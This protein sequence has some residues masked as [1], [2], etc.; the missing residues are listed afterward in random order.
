MAYYQPD[1]VTQAALAKSRTGKK[2]TLAEQQLLTAHSNKMREDMDLTSA[3]NKSLEAANPYNYGGATPQVLLDAL[4][5]EQ[6]GEQTN[7]YEVT[8]L[9]QARNPLSKFNQSMSS[10][11][12]APYNAAIPP[13]YSQPN[14][15]YNTTPQINP[16]VTTP[17]PVSTPVQTNPTATLPFNPIDALPSAPSTV[18]TPNGGLALGSSVGGVDEGKLLAE[19]ELQKD[20]RRQTYEQ[21]VSGRKAMLDELSAVLQKQQ[22]GMM[23][24]QLPGIYED[25]N[26]RGLLRSSALGE[27]L[28][29]E[30]SKLARQTSEQLALQGITDRN[31]AIND[32]GAIEEA[33]LG[34]RGS[35][36]QRRFSLEDFDRQVKAG[37]ELGANA[38]PTVS[39]PSG[40]GSGAIQGGLGGATVGGTVGGVPGAIVGGVTGL[41]GGGAL[42]G[43]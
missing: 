41:L 31:L 43:K 27:K 20:L 17:P 33:Y 40:K 28:G 13:T 15:Q 18:R 24:D 9:E 38:M 4:R 12:T 16:G 14:S 19:A 29:L 34:G 1:A 22:L 30:Q 32:L 21:Q 11:G 36:M 2:L 5:K 25:L 39:Q 42:G 8:A 35:A 7:I 37:K 6:S 23:S 3:K 10:Q 26:T